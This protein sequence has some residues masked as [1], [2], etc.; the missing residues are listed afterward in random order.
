MTCEACGEDA[1]FRRYHCV[2]CRRLVCVYCKERI[3]E[4]RKVWCSKSTAC[5]LIGKAREREEARA[6]AK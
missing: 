2:I 1:P 4:P 6:A 5:V 3:D